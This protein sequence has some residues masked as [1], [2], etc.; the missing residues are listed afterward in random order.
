MSPVGRGATS[1]PTNRFESIKVEDDWDH[2]EFDDSVHFSKTKVPTEYLDDR[3]ESIVSENNSPDLGF[4]FSL[5][6]YRGCSHGCSYCYARPTHEYLGFNAGLDFET[7]IMVKRD[8][9]KL[10][11]KWLSRKSWIPEPIMMSGVT[12]PYQPAEKQFR[13]TRSCLEVA[14]EF[15]QPMRL[16]TKNAMI[17]RDTDLLQELAAK[18]LVQTTISITSLDQSLTRLME[19]R[20]SSP[21]ARL[22]A[23][24]TLS[25]AGIPVNVNTAPIVPGLNDSEIPSLLEASR[26]HGASSAAYI[27]LRMPYSVKEI[28]LDWVDHHQPEIRERIEARVR[29][30]SHGKLS[31]NKFGERMSGS[32]VYADQIRQTF[33][34]FSKK[35]GLDHQLPALRTDLFQVPERN[36]QLRLFE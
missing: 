11:S 19:P 33:K 1:N 6:P 34:V 35:F 3:S 26:D 15:N 17:V 28:F 16:I 36:G 20:T 18:E 2:L 29:M 25:E 22:R 8:C 23:V 4:R 24:R 7:K 31:R 14:I 21:E 13:L 10:F 5:N 30:T 12:D 9:A 27:L 32:G